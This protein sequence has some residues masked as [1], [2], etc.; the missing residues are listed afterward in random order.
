M[1]INYNSFTSKCVLSLTNFNYL[2]NLQK[3]VM[4]GNYLGTSALNVLFESLTSLQVLD[5]IC[6]SS[7]HINIYDI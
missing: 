5:T 2:K 7:I 1:Y 4:S 3:L 6:L